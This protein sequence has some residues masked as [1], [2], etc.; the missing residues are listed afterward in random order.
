[1]GLGL[2]ALGFGLWALGLGL[3]PLGSDMPPGSPA[4]T[5]R[6][7]VWVGAGRRSRC[8]YSCFMI[9]PTFAGEKNSAGEIVPAFIRTKPS[10]AS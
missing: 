8:L 6:Q 1:L 3:Q 10:I 7:T 9:R 4:A 2:W 5:E